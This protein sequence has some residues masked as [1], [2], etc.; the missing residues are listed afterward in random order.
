VKAIARTAAAGRSRLGDCERL[1]NAACASSAEPEPIIGKR[2]R[3]LRET[4][5][6]RL[7]ARAGSANARS[8]RLLQS[9][10]SG[11]FAAPAHRLLRWL[12]SG[13]LGLAAA[14]ATMQK[15][16]ARVPNEWRRVRI[17]GAP[18]SARFLG[19]HAAQS[20]RGRPRRACAV[21][22]R[23]RAEAH[24]GTRVPLRLLRARAC[25]GPQHGGA[26]ALSLATV[27]VLEGASRDLRWERWRAT[28]RSA[29]P[30]C[31]IARADGQPWP[32]R[33]TW[34]V[35]FR[36][37][38]DRG[39]AQLSCIAWR[40][41]S[42]PAGTHDCS[43]S[44]RATATPRSGLTPASTGSFAA[45]LQITSPARHPLSGRSGHLAGD[46]S[47]AIGTRPDQQRP[48]V[49]E[50]GCSATRATARC[51]CTW[52]R[53]RPAA[54]TSTTPATAAKQGRGPVAHDAGL[55]GDAVGCGSG[56]EQEQGAAGAG[57]LLL[58]QGGHGAPS[59]SGMF[60]HPSPACYRLTDRGGPPPGTRMP[61]RN[62]AVFACGAR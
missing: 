19:P 20:W 29:P 41:S 23:R 3:I 36:C 5:V 12:K 49:D 61:W 55:A 54:S 48:S 44:S 17:G 33:S 24:R 28:A 16:R 30:E 15:Q 9:P 35:A 1:G 8:R 42:Q 40:S 10:R 13:S 4:A 52:P 31:C 57:D 47:S 14:P 6:R 58:R 7:L 37:G 34:L 32:C 27:D 62:P 26:R 45:T 38:E 18:C 39:V 2:S 11:S 43:D 50:G 53:I 60:R 59:L 46:D 56:D 51:A 21:G 25:V 22:D